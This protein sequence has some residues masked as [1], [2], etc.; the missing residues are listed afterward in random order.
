M[1]NELF[2]WLMLSLQYFIIGLQRQKAVLELLTHGHQLTV[3]ESLHVL[4]AQCVSV[5]RLLIK[6]S[7]LNCICFVLPKGKTAY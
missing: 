3:N 7:G 6:V 1:R 5:F 4:L 2:S